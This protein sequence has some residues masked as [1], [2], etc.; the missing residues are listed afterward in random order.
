M[1][2]T[3]RFVKA[4]KALNVCCE[5][6]VSMEMF[7]RRAVWLMFRFHVSSLELKKENE[8]VHSVH[9]AGEASV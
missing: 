9:G 4:G 3:C 6:L 5:A 1:L 8:T 7:Q 2:K